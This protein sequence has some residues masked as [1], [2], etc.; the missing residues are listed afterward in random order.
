MNKEKGKKVKRKGVKGVSK[1]KRV[2]EG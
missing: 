1:G 2:V